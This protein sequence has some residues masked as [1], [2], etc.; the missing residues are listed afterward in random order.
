MI[1]PKKKAAKKIASKDKST[2]KI[3]PID[4]RSIDPVSSSVL[5]EDPV[6][7]KINNSATISSAVE[8]YKNGRRRDSYLNCEL[9]LRTHPRH[10]S[11]FH[12]MG[13]IAIDNQDFPLAMR[14][15][16]ESLSIDEDNFLAHNNLGV[17][18]RLLKDSLAA[19]VH[20]E[21]A[22]SLKSDYAEA[23]NN[24]GVVL[25]D[26]NRPEDAL[27]QFKKALKIKPDYDDAKK[28]KDLILKARKG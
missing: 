15:L 2:S 16:S 27:A 25:R 10:A 22:V 28:N 21:K 19:A 20:F 12:L 23:F 1:A 13:I 8:L 6:V 24:L 5:S 14:M 26:L 17:V 9:I 7:K 3:S 11:A 18:Y 4:L